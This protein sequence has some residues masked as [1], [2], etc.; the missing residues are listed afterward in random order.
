MTQAKPQFVTF[1]D[2][3]NYSNEVS[4]EGRYELIA[5]ELVEL[6]PEAEANDFFANHLMILLFSAGL[7]PLRLIRVH[8]CE[9]Q[10]PVLEA[11]DPANRFPDLVV[12]RP[13]HLEL[14]QR[15]LT[16]TREMPPPQLVVEVV[17]P[18]KTNRHRDFV[19]KRAQYA[20]I[21]IGE[22]WILD[23]GAR[24]VLVLKLGG[25]EYVEVGEFC[26]GDAIRSPLFEELTL[27]AEQIFHRE[28]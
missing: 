11:K 2:Y 28:P 10:V 5:G 16:I 23:P 13:E 6:P 21:A 18:G 19:R 8:T 7:L 22:Y 17:S 26:G 14:T 3:L 9:V 4:L 12:L 27:T 25:K 20:A 1:A 15:R 24:S